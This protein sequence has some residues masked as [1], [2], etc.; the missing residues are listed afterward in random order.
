[1][2][3]IFWYDYETTGITPRCDRPLQVAGIRT[4]FELNEIDAPV[5]LYCQPSDDILPHP[6]ACAITGITPSRLAE[7]G[8]SEADFMTR[9][10][11][12]LAAP[13]T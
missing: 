13:G 8:L 1:M 3:S 6:A 5:N 7:Q 11:A 2:T 10:H 12:Q 9:V 4:D